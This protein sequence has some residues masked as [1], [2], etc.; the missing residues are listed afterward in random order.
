MVRNT[1]RKFLASLGAVATTSA[2]TTATSRQDQLSFVQKI[3]QANEVRRRQSS[4]DAW[5][6]HLTERGVAGS[7]DT[8]KLT[9]DDGISTQRYQNR[10]QIDLELNLAYDTDT[11]EGDTTTVFYA[12]LNWNYRWGGT[13]RQCPPGRFTS[14][15]DVAR[16]DGQA[17]RDLAGIVY[18]DEDW[19]RLYD[20]NDQD[21]TLSEHVEYENGS[22]V[23]DK[24]VVFGVH[25]KA[26]NETVRIDGDRYTTI[27]PE[28]IFT[29]GLFLTLEGPWNDPNNVRKVQAD[30]HHIYGGWGIDSISLGGGISTT[31][32]YFTK[33][34]KIDTE[35]NGDAL[36]VHKE[37]ADWAP[38]GS[39]DEAHPGR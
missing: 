39:G 22:Y 11:V 5:K 33:E 2:A 10:S 36:E 13:E 15:Y 31:L 19:E 21:F 28:E 34:M 35:N 12:E 8:A 30:Y 27:P 17:P 23:D 25:D 18:E 24:G 20:N 26:A 29:C 37:D 14:C 4:R 38:E 3:R 32:K 1:R 16:S 6:Q 7:S 9:T